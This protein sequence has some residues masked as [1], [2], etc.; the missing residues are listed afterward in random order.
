MEFL[1]VY[2]RSYLFNVVEH[3]GLHSIRPENALRKLKAKKY[4][5]SKLPEA[6]SFKEEQNLNSFDKAE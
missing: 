1:L 2:E 3:L 5:F 4:R 6:G